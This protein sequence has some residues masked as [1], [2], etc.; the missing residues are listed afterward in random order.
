MKPPFHMPV[1]LKEAIASLNCM[2]GGV[3][4]DGT[5]G[6]GGHAYGILEE[7]APGGILVG[8]DLDDDALLES[9]KR[10][11]VFGNRKFLVKGNYSDI[12]A[13][14]AGL[15]IER[16]DGIL[17][18]LG[19]SSHQLERAERG[20]S[21]SLDAPLDMRMNQEGNLTA[22]DIVNGFTGDKLRK[23]IRDY[24][25]EMRYAKVVSAI[26]ARRKT[27]PIKTTGE[28]ARVVLSAIS[29][30][31]KRGKIHPAT[32]TFQAIRIA[33]NDELAN[34]YK[35]IDDGI[36]SLNSGGRLS[37]ISFHS[38][39]DRIV[40]NA[41]RAWGKGCICPPDL[42]LCI[43]DRDAKLKV[44]TK[45]PVRPSEEE[46]KINPRAR[47]AKLRTALRI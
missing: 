38:L 15:G 11:D 27:S 28:L 25:E 29:E 7:T 30:R 31:S 19:V 24:G 23:I 3:Y 8:I 33:V 40:K 9:R 35:A 14:L 37:V 13:I 42:P 16:V 1:M 36:D 45:K 41:F 5:V 22:A 10:L 39:E 32:K 18:D 2:Q 12:K 34:L 47:S 21:F 17:L 20:F 4:L 44:L 43:C 26:L 46:I 6:G